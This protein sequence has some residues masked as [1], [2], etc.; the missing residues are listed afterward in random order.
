MIGNMQGEGVRF[1]AAKRT[2]MVNLI[3]TQ[4]RFVFSTRP[5]I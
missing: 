2:P 5:L 1:E 3:T 4:S